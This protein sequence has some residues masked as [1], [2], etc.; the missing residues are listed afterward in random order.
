MLRAIIFIDDKELADVKIVNTGKRNNEGKTIYKTTIGAIDFTIYHD[1][2][3]GWEVLL[4]RVLE[5]KIKVN[6]GLLTMKLSDI[7]KVPK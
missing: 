6:A 3:D 7:M 1:R 5:M 4:Q 2:E